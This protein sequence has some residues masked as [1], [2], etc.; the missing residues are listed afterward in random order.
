MLSDL[1]ALL[2][3][4]S[5]QNPVGNNLEYEMLFDQIRQARQSDPDYLPQDEWSVSEP[6]TADW[7]QT[8]TLC[9]NALTE[10][11][12]DLQIACW[13]TEA[14][15]HLHGLTGLSQGID[16][17]SE[18]ISRFWFQCWPSLTEG[19]IAIRRS[20]I[21]RLDRDVAHELLRMP[22]LSHP[23]STLSHWRQVLAFE[24]KINSQPEARDELI[25]Q[26]GDLA[27]DSFNQQAKH[28]CPIEIGKQMALIDAL[29]GG[30]SQLEERYFS[31][32]QDSEGELFNQTRL[33]LKDIADYL[34][35]LVQ[36]VIPVA[37]PV[38]MEE[39]GDQDECVL[40]AAKAAV[41]AVPSSSQTM[42]RER[43][44][45]QMRIIAD[46]FRQSEPSSPVPFLMERAAR[47][48]GMT[49]TEWLEEM[50]SDSNSINEINNVL[51]GQP[52]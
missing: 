47:W 43:A 5:A 34:Q 36:R 52:H 21:V 15:L 46:Y 3:P 49:L 19:G 28:F 38:M 1:T 41:S 16:F 48:A 26:D 42:N 39:P 50:L 18:F 31:L 44:V 29:N 12:K 37:A 8:R 17:L 10:Q 33:T 51:T 20:K 25:S 6:R 32:S 40:V 9:E 11:T 4:V 30:L 22:L 2:T 23:I 24:H 35:R 14:M 13:L 7:V 45:S 27:M